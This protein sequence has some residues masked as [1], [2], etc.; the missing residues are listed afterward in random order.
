MPD[1]GGGIE[2]RG[3]DSISAGGRLIGPG[4]PT[5]VVAEVGVNHNGDMELA[6]KCIDAAAEAGADAVKFQNFR[7]E[8]FIA[9][10]DLEYTYQSQGNVVTESQ[11]EMF[12]R[13]ELDSD[14]LAE[15]KAR[16]DAQGV[17][18][19]STPTS[20]KGIDDLV[21]IQTPLLKNG[22]DCLTHLPL[23]RAMGKT[24]LPTILSTG[25]A[26]PCDVHSAVQAFRETGNQNLIL[27]ACTSAYP[28]PPR[29][30]NV[31]RV[32]T[33]A[34]AFGCLAGFSDH[35]EG[36]AAAVLSVCFGSCVIEKHFTLD[37]ELPGPDHWFSLDAHGLR[38]LVASI[39]NAETA[40]GTGEITP[41]TSEAES[42]KN[43]RL[44]CVAKHD[45]SAGTQLS[46]AVIG[47]SRPG[48]GIPPSML[49]MILGR[50]LKN[51]VNAGHI[52]TLDDL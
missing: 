3:I 38:K 41:S 47:F 48:G 50:T 42:R 6:R 37:R 52:L 7:A 34:R 36:E 29:D 13:L 39:R 19:F 17:I 28:T 31:A 45:L 22:S 18:F 14:A 43:F 15:L 2:N 11:Y 35:T 21:S 51:D 49:D 40:I 33:L 25:M 46:E 10:Q 30:A 12:K 44:S 8:E 5:L 23:V 16:C 20:Q 4:Q 26:D 1:L 27:L 9:D 24:G 32:A